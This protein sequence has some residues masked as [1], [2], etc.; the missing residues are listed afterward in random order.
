VGCW[1]VIAEYDEK[2]E[3]I[4]NIISGKIDNE[5]LIEDILYAAKGGKFVETNN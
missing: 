5:L 4:I 2:K 3:N 1:L